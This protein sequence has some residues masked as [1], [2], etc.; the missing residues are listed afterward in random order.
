MNRRHGRTLT[1][2]EVETVVVG[3]KCRLSVKTQCWK[4]NSEMQESHILI[5]HST[6]AG[7]HR[8]FETTQ[9]E[10]DEISNLQTQVN[11]KNT[12]KM[13]GYKSSQISV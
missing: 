8:G 11:L 6:S 9:T 12:T 5:V 7:Q 3:F 4:W 10:R 1:W 13:C 2:S